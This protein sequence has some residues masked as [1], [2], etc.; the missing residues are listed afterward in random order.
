MGRFTWHYTE[1][2]DLYLASRILSGGYGDGDWMQWA[3]DLLLQHL[4][5]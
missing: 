1:R 2:Q 4:E 3:S 5:L